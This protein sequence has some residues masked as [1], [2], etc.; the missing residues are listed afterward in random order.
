[1]FE[2]KDMKECNTIKEKLATL[3]SLL[4]SAGVF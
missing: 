1:M 4:L 2:V 3:L